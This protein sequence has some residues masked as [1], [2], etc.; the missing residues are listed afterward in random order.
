[1]TLSFVALVVFILLAAASSVALIWSAGQV[2][3]A[4]PEKPGEW[5]TTYCPNCH[6]PIG[7]PIWLD[8][9]SGQ[10]AYCFDC[11]RAY[12]ETEVEWRESNTAIGA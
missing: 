10:F 7:A 3:P 11:Q 6:A 12:T 5:Q 4:T 1:M 9:T 2:A 8:L